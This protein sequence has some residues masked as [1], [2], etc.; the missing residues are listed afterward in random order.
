M[1]Y[2]EEEKKMWLEDWQQS[3]KS[4]WSYAKENRLNPHTFVSV[5][6]S[7]TSLKNLLFSR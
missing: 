5:N 3:G 6:S 1:Q 7:G 2:S 4:A